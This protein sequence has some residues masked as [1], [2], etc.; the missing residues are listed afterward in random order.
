MLATRYNEVVCDRTFT[1][2]V[3]LTQ[4]LQPL[5][6]ASEQT[7]GVNQS[8]A[9][10]MRTLV[11]V[12]SGGGSLKDINWM[13]SR[14]YRVLTKDYSTQR[15]RK[16]A[17]SV[18]QWFEDPAQPGRQFG[19]VTTANRD[20]YAQ[21]ML[22]IALRCRK[23]NGQWAIGV[24]V[25]NLNPDEVAALM[26]VELDLKTDLAG[27]W[28]AYVHCYDQRG[29][30]VETSFKQDN[31]ALGTKKCNKKRFEAQ[32]MLTQLNALAHNVLVWAQHWLTAE[33]PALKQI[34][35]FRLMRD[36][37]TTT[38]RLLF[39]ESGQLI[40]IRLNAD[41][42]LVRPWLHALSKLLDPEHVAVNLDKT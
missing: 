20:D 12:D 42:T 15:A 19:V 7:L 22:R 36:V 16:F 5:L 4:A 37:F 13:L 23:N 25:T 24:L 35:F 41:D 14:G 6:E 17:D 3:Q 2:T 30:G 32:Q 31:Q 10:R 27:L 40:E 11:R 18:T 39:D 9:K 8:S 21:P 28:L 26:A 29:G 1:G 33:M 34:G 38:G